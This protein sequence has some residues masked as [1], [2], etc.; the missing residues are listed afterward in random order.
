MEK[1]KGLAVRCLQ[2]GSLDDWTLTFDRQM[3]ILFLFFAPQNLN[4]K[5]SNLFYCQ[6]S[7][8]VNP[9]PPF[10][11][12]LGTQRGQSPKTKT[13]NKVA[14]ECG[15][16]STFIF[17]LG[18]GILGEKWRTQS[19]CQRAQAW[20]II[21]GAWHWPISFVVSSQGFVSGPDGK[22]QCNC[23]PDRQVQ[24]YNQD[25]LPDPTNN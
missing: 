20:S 16:L 18:R 7:F 23:K 9:C 3:K 15:T 13:T 22:K 10:L 1:K 21:G 2:Y 8:W 17:G 24:S 6:L 19:W 5:N 11:F 4:C 12:L 25:I 14:L